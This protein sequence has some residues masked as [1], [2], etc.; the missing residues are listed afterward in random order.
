MSDMESLLE[1]MNTSSDSGLRLTD[2]GRL[3]VIITEEL[4]D[5]TNNEPLA[6]RV[7]DRAEYEGL[8]H[9]DFCY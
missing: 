1:R 9:D 5:T 3:A 2:K 7:A 8:L 4:R 6:F